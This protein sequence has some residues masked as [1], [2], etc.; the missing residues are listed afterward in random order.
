MLT[1]KIL[2]EELESLCTDPGQVHITGEIYD[3]VIARAEA[4][5]K[6]IQDEENPLTK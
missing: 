3:A 4:S 1:L 5:C 6:V 2:W